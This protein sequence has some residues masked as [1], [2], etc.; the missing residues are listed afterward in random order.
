VAQ[1]RPV[2]GINTG[3]RCTNNSSNGNPSY[4]REEHVR[5]DLREN[6]VL[7]ISETCKIDLSTT[8]MSSGSRRTAGNKHVA[9]A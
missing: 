4:L 6:Q 8:N 9:G 5:C 1:H 3:E 7:T 2:S